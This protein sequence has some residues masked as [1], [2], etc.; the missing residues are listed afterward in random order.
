VYNGENRSAFGFGSTDFM[1]LGRVE[2]LPLGLFNDYSEGDF[3]R[4]DTPKVSLGVG[5]A[6]APNAKRV[7]VNQG[8]APAD[9][10]TTDFHNLTADMT[11]KWKGFALSGEFFWRDGTRHVGSAVTATGTPVPEEAVRSGTGWFAQAGYLLPRLPFEVTARVGQV[12]AA[13]GSRLTDKNEAGVAVSFYPGQPPFKVQ[14]D[15]FRLW[16]PGGAENQ[17][18]VQMQVSL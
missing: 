1:Y 6:Y 15:Y 10:G 5:Y 2:V 13:P 9:G 17:F 8:S 12:L 11:F 7:K 4:L 14:A 16:G 18:R 3:E